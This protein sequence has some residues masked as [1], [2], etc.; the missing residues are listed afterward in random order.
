MTCKVSTQTANRDCHTLVVSSES[1]ARAIVLARAPRVSTP[2]SYAFC[3]DGVVAHMIHK[4][5]K[6]NH[7]PMGTPRGFKV[8]QGTHELSLRFL[9]RL[10]KLLRTRLGRHECR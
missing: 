6:C 2:Y 9:T 10:S 3:N 7:M 5:Q 8:R 1:L 4:S